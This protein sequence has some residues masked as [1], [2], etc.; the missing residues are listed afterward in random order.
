MWDVDLQRLQHV[1]VPRRRIRFVRHPQ[2]GQSVRVTG[3]GTEH[4]PTFRFATM[5]LALVVVLSAACSATNSSR[6]GTRPFS[7][8][9]VAQVLSRNSPAQSC[10]TLPTNLTCLKLG[11]QLGG[12]TDVRGA[13]VVSAP[14]PQRWN[15]VLEVDSA[16]KDQINRHLGEQLAF[17]IDGKAWAVVDYT[18]PIGS[19]VTIA[20]EWSDNATARDLANRL[21]ASR[22]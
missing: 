8:F 12:G 10:H 4:A 19:D 6:H 13:T 1:A 16:M 22:N 5:G 21:L 2:S 3:P 18:N 14:F 11:P 15:V 17:V 20:G 7:T 9:G